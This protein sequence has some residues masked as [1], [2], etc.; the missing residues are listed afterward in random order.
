MADIREEFLPDKKGAGKEKIP[1]N[2]KDVFH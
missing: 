1:F 2:I